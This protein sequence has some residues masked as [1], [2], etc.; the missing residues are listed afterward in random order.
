MASRLNTYPN[1]ETNTYSVKGLALAPFH[2][3]HIS[4]ERFFVFIFLIAQ[5][6]FFYYRMAIVYYYSELLLLLLLRVRGH[7]SG[8]CNYADRLVRVWV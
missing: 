6:F 1:V 3:Y 2:T 7:P 4:P 5:G 8:I